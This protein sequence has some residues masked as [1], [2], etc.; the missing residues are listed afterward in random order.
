ML[1]STW[2]APLGVQRAFSAKVRAVRLS[3]V[4]IASRWV[5]IPVV[6]GNGQISG[7]LYLSMPPSDVRGALV[8]RGPGEARAIEDVGQLVVH[9][10]KN[11][12]AVIVRALRL[13]E[14][15]SDSADRK[16]GTEIACSPSRDGDGG[17][18]RIVNAA[19]T[20][21]TS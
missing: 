21:P 12:L 14:G 19:A 4:S 1:A 11:F 2:T 16:V 6:G 8:S 20:A 5:E 7:V 18:F 9:D 15:Q 3:G 13:L 17:I 10:I